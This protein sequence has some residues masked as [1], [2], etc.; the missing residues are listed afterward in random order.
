MSGY[1]Y[2]VRDTRD[3]EAKADPEPMKN[4]WSHPQDANQYLVLNVSGVGTVIVARK[5]KRQRQP[6]QVGW[7]PHDY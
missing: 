1:K 4:K 7:D 3:G 5:R 6:A 2:E